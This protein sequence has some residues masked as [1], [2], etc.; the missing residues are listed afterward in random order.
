MKIFTWFGSLF[1][2]KRELPKVQHADKQMKS[3]GP[4][5]PPEKKQL[6]MVTFGTK[7]NDVVDRENNLNPVLMKVGRVRSVLAA[8]MIINGD[9]ELSDYGVRIQAHITGNVTQRGSSLVIIDKD[10]VVE[11]EI[12]GRYIIVLGKVK[13]KIIGERIVVGATALIEGDVLYRNTFTPIAGAKM[14][15]QIQQQDEPLFLDEVSAM[16]SNPERKIGDDVVPQSGLIQLVKDE[17]KPIANFSRGSIMPTM[18]S[19]MMSNPIMA[20]K[21]VTGNA[22]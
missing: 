19:Y 4:I 12:R 2:E 11:G 22:L 8:D 14:R 21:S 7:N 16:P 10:S 20:S 18:P 6:E 9:V 3:E 15:G 1:I 5:P 13:G 17:A